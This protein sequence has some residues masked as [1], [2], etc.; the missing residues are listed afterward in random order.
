MGVKALQL[1]A[2]AA[3]LVVVQGDGDAVG[4]GIVVGK[5]TYACMQSVSPVNHK[6]SQ[7]LSWSL[8]DLLRGCIVC[9]HSAGGGDVCS[10]Y[11]VDRVVRA[12]HV[13]RWGGD[14][15]YVA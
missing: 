9:V 12:R 7:F 13:K 6:A 2:A 10:A 15:A 1:V 14:D 5:N 4:D 8:L 11:D 3:V